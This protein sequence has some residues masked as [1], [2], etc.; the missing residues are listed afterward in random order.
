MYLIFENKDFKMV[1]KT[2]LSNVMVVY[3]IKPI[4]II[5]NTFLHILQC[6][7]YLNS[8]KAIFSYA[9]NTIIQ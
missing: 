3:V 8:T 4:Q 1:G 5:A 9:I 6:F 7:K 2:I